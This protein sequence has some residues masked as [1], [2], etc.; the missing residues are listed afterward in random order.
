MARETDVGLGNIIIGMGLSFE[1]ST[2][3][4]NQNYRQ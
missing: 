3:S 4:K 1:D 2:D